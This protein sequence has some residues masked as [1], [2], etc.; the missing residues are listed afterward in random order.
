M[1]LLRNQPSAL[2][3]FEN[4]RNMVKISTNDRMDGLVHVVRHT[5]SMNNY[6]PTG[7]SKQNAPIWL[8]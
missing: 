2:R 4:I 1:S 6:L 8:N 7:S 5:Y 3:R